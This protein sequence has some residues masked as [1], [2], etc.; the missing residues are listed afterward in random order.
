MGKKN[1]LLRLAFFPI[2]HSPLPSTFMTPERWKPVD[3]LLQ[4]ALD[5]GPAERAA[6][7]VEACGGALG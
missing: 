1:E 4:D 7:L 6:F 5:R 3:Q 2:P